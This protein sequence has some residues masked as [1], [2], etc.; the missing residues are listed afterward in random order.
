MSWH[1]ECLPEEYCQRQ[2][3]SKHMPVVCDAISE[4]CRN[5]R[6]VLSSINVKKE[7]NLMWINEVWAY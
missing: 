6:P 1:A 7:F 5:F 3:E 4:F 2:S